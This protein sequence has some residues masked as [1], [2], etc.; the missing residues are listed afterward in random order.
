MAESLGS[1]ETTV[2]DVLSRAREPLSVREVHE[3]LC[4]RDLAYTTVLTVLDRLH[5]KGVVR[6]EKRGRAFYYEPVV[7][8][9]QW[10]GQRAAT[11]LA[12][13]DAPSSRAVLM[14]FLDGA[15]RASPD[16]LNELTALLNERRRAGKKR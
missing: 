5:E 3:L 13:R 9:E 10:R 14:A 4:K 6:R 11:L 7:T 12:G 8:S 2:L 15:E 1:L 16:V